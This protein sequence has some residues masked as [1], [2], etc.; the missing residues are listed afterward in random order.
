M[1]PDFSEFSYGYAVTEELVTAMKAAVVAAPVFP[2]LYEE[3]KKG[4]YEGALRVCSKKSALRRFMWI[5]GYPAP[6]KPRG[7]SY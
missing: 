6:V 1:N 4:G 2:S 7:K 5:S 3:G